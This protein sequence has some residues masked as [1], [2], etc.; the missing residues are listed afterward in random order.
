M[1]EFAQD[2]EV[3]H[4]AKRERRVALLAHRRALPEAVRLA[5]AERLQAEL[6]TLLRRLRPSRVT[7]Y[8]PVGTEPGGP[9]LPAVLAAALPAGAQ[10]LL[11]VLRDDL[12]LDWAAWTGPAD[13]VA[14]GRGIREPASP[15]L[16][17]RAITTADLVVLPG[18][19]VDRRGVRL[20]R[21]GGSYDRAL[22][23]LPAT[24]RTVVPLYDGE[25]LDALPAA[26]HDR[27]VGAVVTPTGGLHP[28][29]PPAGVVPHTC[30]G[31]TGG[32]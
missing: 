30:A 26:P 13:M 20:G 5:A 21:G 12:D 29:A 7:A 11:P 32:R 16:G 1:P 25:L 24:A 31:R 27:P 17:V 3:T 28:L 15:R 19:A 23:R 6:V 2:A 14:A 10:L 22:A 18:L 4:E 9:D 8:A